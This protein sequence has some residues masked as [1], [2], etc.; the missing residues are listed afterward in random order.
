MPVFS[1]P[2]RTY[3]DSRAQVE[4]T[5]KTL[6]RGYDAGLISAD[7]V[8]RAFT[9]SL[10][11]EVVPYWHG[12][13]WSFTGHTEI[14]GQGEIACGYFVSTTLLHTG[15][16][17]N[18]Y[19]L[20]QQSPSDEALMLSLGDTV[21]VTRRETGAKALEFWR[22]HLRDGLYFVGLGEGHVGY[23]LKQG[24]GLYFI[25]ANYTYPRGVQMQR[26][27]ESVLAGFQDFYLA[28]ITHNQRLMEYWMSGKK[29]PLQSEGVTVNW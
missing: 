26:A 27:E 15:L 28:N 20:A 2:D 7:S 23:L 10:L 6:K 19:R 22:S 9:N 16:N 12:T 3:L 29:I 18:R 5:R 4:Q 24:A 11:E 14:P 8:G 17:I 13:S 25:H 21:R 1:R